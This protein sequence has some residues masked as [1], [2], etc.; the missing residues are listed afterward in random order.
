VILLDFVAVGLASRNNP[1][2][3]AAL[4]ITMTYD[5]H[6]DGDAQPQE[7]EPLFFVRVLRIRDYAGVFIQESRPR[8][9]EPVLTIK[10]RSFV[11]LR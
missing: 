9:R 6:P 11:R 2:N 1:N 10:E 3:V 7:H 5:Q 4:S 8:L